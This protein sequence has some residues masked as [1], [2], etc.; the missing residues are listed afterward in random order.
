MLTCH[1][2]T[3][4]VPGR[5]NSSMAKTVAVIGASSNRDKFGN[6]AFRAFLKQG[7]T[8]IPINPNEPE[9]EGHRTYASVLDFPDGIDL[10]TFYVPP[11][12]GVNVLGDVA[13]KHIPEVWLNPG[14]DDSRVVARA[15]ELGL[16]TVRQCSIIAIGESP[17]RF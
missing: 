9:V 1:V 8:T 12:V 17:G 13:E 3:C 11:H 10:A 15:R 5:Y 16:K 4:D 14:A 2:L 6:K 7:Y